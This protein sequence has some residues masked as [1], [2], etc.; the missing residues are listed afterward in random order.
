M[1]LICPAHSLFMYLFHVQADASRSNG[2]DT[3]EGVAENERP[4]SSPF[5]HSSSSKGSSTDTS[6]PS[7]GGRAT[8]S[9]RVARFK[10]E[11]ASP[12][13]NLGKSHE[14]NCLM[15]FLM[16]ANRPKDDTWIKCSITFVFCG[17]ELYGCACRLYCGSFL[18]ADAL[19]ELAWSGV[20]PDMRPI[21]W[22]LLVV[23]L[24]SA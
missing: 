2:S 4:S 13:V 8:D 11:L 12:A 7:T 21:V 14:L 6:R 1:L 3:S 9:A 18:L 10:K 24:F 5:G 23:R 22:R 20:P 19:R 16:S 17:K 15:N